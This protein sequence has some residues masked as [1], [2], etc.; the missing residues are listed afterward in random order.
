MDARRI[1]TLLVQL[2]WWSL[3]ATACLTLAIVAA[4][5]AYGGLDF[6]RRIENMFAAASL[7]FQSTHF[8]LS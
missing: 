8:Q 6:D 3:A 1:V 4:F 5:A 7:N 2:R